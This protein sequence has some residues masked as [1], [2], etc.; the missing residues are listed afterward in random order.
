M[1]AVLRAFQ[2]ILQLPEKT[3]PLCVAD[4]FE[5]ING[6]VRTMR[7][8]SVSSSPELLSPL[9]DSGHLARL[10]HN[11]RKSSSTHSFP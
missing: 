4:V 9:R 2:L 1:A 7:V 3:N 6:T 5:G 8:T 11:S 10:R